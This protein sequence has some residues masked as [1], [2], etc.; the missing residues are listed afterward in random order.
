MS[1]SFY[2]QYNFTNKRILPGEPSR[3]Q[4]NRQGKVMVMVMK[5]TQIYFSIVWIMDHGSWIMDY[6]T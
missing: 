3:W 5:L 2:K 1:L 4:P 6:A